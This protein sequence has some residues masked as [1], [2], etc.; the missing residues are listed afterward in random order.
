MPD[1]QT[2]LHARCLRFLNYSQ[3]L[4]SFGMRPLDGT[5]YALGVPDL[6]YLV[7]TEF[8]RYFL[9]AFRHWEQNCL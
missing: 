4:F 2:H 9:E 3:E 7:F 1:R 5:K 8:I 6:D